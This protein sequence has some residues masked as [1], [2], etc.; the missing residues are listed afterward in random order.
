MILVVCKGAADI[1]VY[2]KHGWTGNDILELLGKDIDV[3]VLPKECV[4]RC[5]QLYTDTLFVVDKFFEC[6]E[7]VDKHT[8]WMLLCEYMIPNMLLHGPVMESMWEVYIKQVERL[9]S[10][11]VMYEIMGDDSMRYTLSHMMENVHVYFKRVSPR[12]AHVLVDSILEDAN[13]RYV[14][15]K[16]RIREEKKGYRLSINTSY[17]SAGKK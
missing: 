13:K 14:K 5:V 7:D 9:E 10:A 3:S 8:M 15:F 4:Y 1:V 6:H 17:L 16:E 12:F 2:K 11:V